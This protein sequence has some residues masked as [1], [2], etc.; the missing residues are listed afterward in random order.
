M[1]L[2][3]LSQICYA[4]LYA[5]MDAPINEDILRH[6]LINIIRS[7][8]MKFKHEFGTNM[9]IVGDGYYSWRRAKFQYYKARRRQKREE[10][11]KFDWKNIFAMFSKI[12]TEFSV[13]LPY[14]FVDVAAAEA[15]D[16]I[17]VICKNTPIEEKILILSGDRDFVQLQESPNVQQ[18]NP[19]SHLWVKPEVS[20][21]FDLE[22][23]I[24]CGDVGDG[25]PNIL[26]DSD[27]FITEGKRQTVMTK[28]RKEEL[29]QKINECRVKIMNMQANCGSSGPPPQ[30]PLNY[31]RNCLLIDFN[32]IPP[33]IQL[34]ILQ[35]YKNVNKSEE[36]AKRRSRLLSYFMEKRL[37][38]L[39]ENIGDF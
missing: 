11:T 34:E 21:Q 36:L 5:L 17:A 2:V 23:K 12:K 15:D 27:T 33:D 9:V 16:V 19:V 37:N 6:V 13:V 8:F 10:D 31:D 20:P 32:N 30:Y 38:N 3:D 1:I 26:S 4:S 22:E 29:K 18:F 28:K 14:A 7:N 35:E 24:I 39:I 25:I